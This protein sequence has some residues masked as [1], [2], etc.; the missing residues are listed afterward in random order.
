MGSEVC[1]GLHALTLG[2]LTI[3][4]KPSG[5]KSLN[6]IDDHFEVTVPF[7]FGDE[8]KNEFKN[9]GSSNNQKYCAGGCNL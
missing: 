1:K 4:I 8:F 5:W 2:V 3:Y 7:Y 9:Q 6:R